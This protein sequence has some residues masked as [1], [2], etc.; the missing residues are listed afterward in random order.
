MRGDRLVRV[1]ATRG[2]AVGPGEDREVGAI[3]TS[4]L[5][6][7]PDRA[8]VERLL[9]DE[10]AEAQVVERERGDVVGQPLRGA[11]AAEDG[12]GEVGAGAVVPDEGDAAVREL[13]AGGRLGRV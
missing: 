6:V 11:Q 3:R 12:A 7:A 10:E 8:A 4:G 13:A 2:E 5:Q 9:V 1:S